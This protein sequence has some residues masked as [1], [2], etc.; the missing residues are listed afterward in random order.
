MRDWTSSWSP[1]V[2]LV[3]FV[4][5][6]PPDGEV[7]TGGERLALGGENDRAAFGDL[8]ERLIGV[9]GLSDEVEAEE[10]VRRVAELDEGHM[11]VELDPD[12]LE[13]VEVLH[14][15]LSPAVSSSRPSGSTCFG[16]CYIVSDQKRNDTSVA[17]A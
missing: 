2:A 7:G 9:R 8:V 1:E 4:L 13:A 14:P 15:A 11:A 12:L 6:D 16:E 5:P 17:R 3:A 10:V